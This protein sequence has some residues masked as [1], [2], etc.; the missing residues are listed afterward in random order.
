MNLIKKFLAIL[1]ILAGVFPLYGEK[2]VSLSPAVTELVIY[3]GG[4]EQLCGRSSACTMP[5]V[6][7]LPVAGDLGL[8][9]VEAVLKNRATMLITDIYHP[10]AR[11]DLLRRCGVKVE[12]L[13]NRDIAD[14]PENLRRISKLL[15]LPEAEKKAEILSGMI[16]QLHRDRPEKTSKAVVLFG[17][18]PLVSCGKETFISSA[19]ELAGLENCAT[20][21][22]QGY[23]VLAPEFLL[24]AMP[25]YILIVG[26]PEA[27][28]KE[29]FQRSIYRH[30]P[31]C[32]QGNIIFLAPEKW[33]RLTPALLPE[34]GK[35]QQ[36]VK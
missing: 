19:M 9:F 28:A 15:A 34:I 13:A 21:A 16:A 30:I 31:A 25:E 2:V 33:A 35:L 4:K 17:V 26:V 5:E 22:G 6:D 8:P 20:T 29:F 10:Q 27:V 14:L 7:Y 3:A 23:F 18:S 32:R 12:L 36:L 11:W 1:A 24:S